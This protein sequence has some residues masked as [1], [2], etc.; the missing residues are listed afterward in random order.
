MQITLIYIYIYTCK[1]YKR[2]ILGAPLHWRRSYVEIPMTVQLDS[3]VWASSCTIR[4]ATLRDNNA[5]TS[6]KKTSFRRHADDSS[7]RF[8]CFSN[9]VY[10]QWS[11][12]ARQQ[13]TY[14]SKKHPSDVMPTIVQLDSNALATSYTM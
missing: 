7:T 12:V 11:D 9:V 1:S 3:N 4:V 5:P 14:I 2:S 13:C 10:H 8:Q 6:L